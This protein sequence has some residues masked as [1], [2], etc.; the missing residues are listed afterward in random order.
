MAQEVECLLFKC[1]AHSSKTQPHQ[2]KKKKEEEK[3]TLF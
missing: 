1:E 3:I 2:K